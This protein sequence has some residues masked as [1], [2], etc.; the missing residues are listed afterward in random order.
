MK[1]VVKVQNNEDEES[2][3]NPDSL[4]EDPDFIPMNAEVKHRQ[5]N[6]FT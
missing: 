1:F 5:V 3:S 4:T 2:A 6:S